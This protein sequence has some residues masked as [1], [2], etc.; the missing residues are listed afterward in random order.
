MAV[1]ASHMLSLAVCIPVSGWKADRY[2][3]HRVF[4]SAV[5][6]FTFSSILCGLASNAPMLVA[7]RVLQGIGA[8]M[9]MPVRREDGPHVHHAQVAIM[10]STR[11]AMLAVT[12][13]QKI[14]TTFDAMWSAP[15]FP[16][17]RLTWPAPPPVSP[18]AMHPVRP[19][20]P[21]LRRADLFLVW[22]DERPERYVRWRTDKGSLPAQ[23]VL[24]N[25][26]SSQSCKRQLGDTPCIRFLS[27]NPQ[28]IA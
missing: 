25:I 19:F 10:A 3:T 16:K 28:Y 23:G 12:S 27:V 11:S 14:R 7:A 8:A 4:G 17:G 18:C 24:T 20:D 15:H 26:S 6:T 2:G 21:P 1:V 5:A 13:Q 9:M 22:S